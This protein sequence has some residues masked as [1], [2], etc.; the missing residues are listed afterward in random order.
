MDDDRLK[1]PDGRPDYF[2]EVDTLNRLVVIFPGTA[3]LRAKNRQETRMSF[4]MENVD[5]IITVNGFPLLSNA[6]SGS[7]E[8]MQRSTNALYAGYDARRKKEDVHRVDLEDKAE[9]QALESRIKKRP[10]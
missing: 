4:L 5:Q 1:N 8:L 7:K 2:D 3:E 6:G 10:R 9:L